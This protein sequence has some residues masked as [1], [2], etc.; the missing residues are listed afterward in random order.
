MT[1]SSNSC[2]AEGRKIDVSGAEDTLHSEMCI[3]LTLNS[4]FRRHF[5]AGKRIDRDDRVMVRKKSI[6]WGGFV[7]KPWIE[8]LWLQML[9]RSRLITL[10]DLNNSFRWFNRKPLNVQSLKASTICSC[11][12]RNQTLTKA[13]SWEICFISYHLS[14]ILRVNDKRKNRWRSMW[15]LSTLFLSGRL[16]RHAWWNPITTVWRIQNMWSGHL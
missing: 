10:L 6:S 5:W 9:Q 15:Q 1:T 8:S 12:P 13:S 7:F 4:S 14:N 16:I 2:M 3:N 11:R